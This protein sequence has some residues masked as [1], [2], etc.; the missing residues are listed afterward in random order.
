MSLQDLHIAKNLLTKF[1]GFMIQIYSS[2]LYKDWVLISND[3]FAFIL[4]QIL[5]FCNDMMAECPD[6]SCDGECFEAI[7]LSFM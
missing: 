7:F 4:K 5:H 1:S 6:N 2:N 3:V